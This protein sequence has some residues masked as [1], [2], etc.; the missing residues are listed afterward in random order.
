MAAILKRPVQMSSQL[1]GNILD[2]FDNN[3][4]NLELNPKLLLKYKGGT[5]TLEQLLKKIEHLESAMADYII[6][7]EKLL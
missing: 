1:R 7:E 3:E 2:S 5:I 4:T 6:F